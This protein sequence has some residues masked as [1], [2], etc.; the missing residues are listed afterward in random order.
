MQMINNLFFKLMMFDCLQFDWK[1]KKN[2][3]NKFKN[4]RIIKIKNF[5]IKNNQQLNVISI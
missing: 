5:G 4:Q 3:K 2:Q 1:F